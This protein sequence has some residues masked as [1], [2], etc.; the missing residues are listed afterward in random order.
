MCFSCQL[1]PRFTQDHPAANALQ[2]WMLKKR[3]FAPVQSLRNL[4]NSCW[5]WFYIVT[6]ST[7]IFA[8]ALFPFPSL[9]SVHLPFPIS[10]SLNFL[11]KGFIFHV[12]YVFSSA[13]EWWDELNLFCWVPVKEL[14]MFF[15]SPKKE[16]MQLLNVTVLLC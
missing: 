3:L 2:W 15:E 14:L 6:Y 11:G 1:S 4:C 13:P 5:D 8:V 12:G 16:T 10:I 7:T 9:F